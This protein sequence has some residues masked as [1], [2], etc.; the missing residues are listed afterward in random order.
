MVRKLLTVQELENKK[1]AERALKAREKRQQD[2]YNSPE[3][4]RNRLIYSFIVLLMIA[5]TVFMNLYYGY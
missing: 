3:F 2:Y 1:A 5:F 4:R